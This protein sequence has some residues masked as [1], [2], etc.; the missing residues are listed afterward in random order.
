MPAI[1]TIVLGFVLPV[2][3]TAIV[4]AIAGHNRR[5]IIAPVF[6]AAVGTAF[7][8]LRARPHLPGT[9][10]VIEW[11]FWLAVALGVLGALDAIL[12]PPFWMRALFLLF[13]WRMAIRL[14]LW[15]LIPATLT[16][17]E[18]WMDF[19]SLAAL[20]WW[21]T[22]EKV[23]ESSP[24]LLAP[25]L[26]LILSIGSAAI[27]TSWHI[28]GSATVAAGIAAICAAAALAALFRSRISLDRGGAAAVGL[29]LLAHP[30]PRV[31]LYE[32]HAHWLATNY[33][34]SFA[35]FA[36]VGAGRR[37]PGGG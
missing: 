11:V 5:W 15:P 13:I 33:R 20:A 12:R 17:P 1:S 27:L 31:F 18:E 32:R 16:L 4:L 10:D 36:D 22:L 23:S 30:G 9:G 35:D 3:F 21:W 29:T 28:V 24:G 26:L 7:W 2:L 6:G 14:M 19:L 37:S 25:L 8:S 34:G